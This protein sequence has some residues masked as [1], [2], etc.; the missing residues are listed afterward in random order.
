MSQQNVKLS[1]ICCEKKMKVD[2]KGEEKKKKRK[3]EQEAGKFHVL[4]QTK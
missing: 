3:A 4:F 2:H 1:N